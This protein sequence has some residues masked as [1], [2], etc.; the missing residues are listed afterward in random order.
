LGSRQAQTF[1]EQDHPDHRALSAGA[2]AV[3]LTA[4]RL[5]PRNLQDSV[6]QSVIVENKPG[7]NQPPSAIEA[8]G[9][10]RTRDGP[11]PSSSSSDSPRHDQCPSVRGSNYDP[12]TEPG[13][14]RQGGEQPDHPDRQRQERESH[15]LP[16]SVAAAKAKPLSYGRCGPA[17]RRPISPLSLPPARN[18]D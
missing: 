11:Q 4:P 2:A 6:G 9:A 18:W 10:K 17:A 13:A 5:S 14:G 16:I 1:S 7:A 8:P 15:P 12:L 3:D